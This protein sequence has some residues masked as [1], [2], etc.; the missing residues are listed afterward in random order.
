LVAKLGSNLTV[1]I[2]HAQREA[3]ERDASVGGRRSSR[4][5]AT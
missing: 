5:Q 3:G 1:Q 2:V 4:R